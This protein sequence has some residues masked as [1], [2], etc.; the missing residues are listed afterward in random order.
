MTRQSS[1]MTIITRFAP[2]P[3]GYMHLG[4]AYSA[5]FASANGDQFIVRIEDIDTAR[6]RSEFEDAILDDLAWM[7]LSWETPIRRQSEHFPDYA[8]ALDTLKDRNLIYPCFC[9]RKEIQR[10]IKSAGHAP[11]GPEGAIYPGTCRNIAKLEQ[12]ERIAAGIPHAFR[13]K[14]DNATAQT[15]PLTWHDLALGKIKARPNIFGDIIIA[16]KDTPTSYHLAVT[17]DDFLQGITLV[18]RG[19]D[20][21]QSSHIHR[22]LQALLGFD[23]PTYHHHRLITDQNGD[24]LAKRNKSAT[25][26]DLR[27]KGYAPSQIRALAGLEI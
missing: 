21:F 12:T 4:H 2:S 20:L 8:A 26:Q 24:R 5:L 19:S 6:C 15:G 7:G 3:T 17:V 9:T 22:L 11:H 1:V 23:P 25:L 18:T 27:A 10:E 14:T 13:L 16:R